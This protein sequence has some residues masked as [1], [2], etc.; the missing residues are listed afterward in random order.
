MVLRMSEATHNS[1]RARRLL[2]WYPRIWR[3]RYGEEFLDLMEQEI[4]ERPHSLR[5]SGNIAYRGSVSRLREVG[6]AASTIDPTDQPRA[7][8]AT[9]FISS[10]IFALVAMNF[11]SIAMLTWNSYGS[12]P[13]SL[14]ETLWTGSLTVLAGLVIAMVV[15]MF[16]AVLWTAV[17]RMA[18][19]EGK[20]VPALL[21][22]IVASV[23]FLCYALFN[24]LRYVIARG[25]IDWAHPGQAIKQLAGVSNSVLGTVNW[26]WMSPRESLRLGLNYVSGLIPVVFLILAIAAA[27]LARRIN[28][29]VA[30]NRLG[31]IALWA[32][33][34]TMI[35]FVL[36]FFGLMA[37]GSAL[38]GW[39]FDESLGY[40]PLVVEFV[41]MVV[42]AALAIQSQLCLRR[43]RIGLLRTA[44]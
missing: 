28:F 6:L 39:G 20:G 11:W 15:V 32:I 33:A 26:I 21:S 1:R 25:G 27:V 10:A 12:A 18:K 13:A 42:M 16:T 41:M 30:T 22:L 8:V 40:P 38:P 29:S 17:R 34:A 3:E 19:G 36:A 9:L 44:P 4:D 24:E 43:N 35:A 14:A 5:R 7:A 23:G 31:R 2:R 37:M